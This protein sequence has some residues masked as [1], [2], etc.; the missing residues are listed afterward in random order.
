QWDW[1]W[2][3]TSAAAR[4]RP[5]AFLRRRTRRGSRHSPVRSLSPASTTSTFRARTPLARARRRPQPSYTDPRPAQPRRLSALGRRAP[6]LRARVEQRVGRR[7]G[8][9][10]ILV[11]GGQDQQILIDEAT[12]DVG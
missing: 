4:A 2:I 9:R 11:I 3:S 10:T 6:P 7:A 1:R 12:H 8:R 5:V